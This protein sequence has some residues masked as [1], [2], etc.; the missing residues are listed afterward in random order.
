MPTV[1]LTFASKADLVKRLREEGDHLREAFSKTEPNLVWLVRDSVAPNTFR[2]LRRGKRG[3]AEVFREWAYG[4]LGNRKAV[5]ELTK[6][7]CQ[8]D[9]DKWLGRLAT[10]LS[11][12]WKKQVGLTMPFGPSRKLPNLLLNELAKWSGFSDEERGRLIS[13]LHVPLDSYTLIAIRNCL[14]ETEAS[15]VMIPSSPT[16]RSVEHNETY[17]A[18]QAAVR[19]IAYEAGTQPICIDVLA[20]NLTH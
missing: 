9:Y 20:W 10:D 15:W 4:W 2:G 6:L 16:M 7:S 1:A 12:Q 5:R 13:F 19:Q 8:E 17:V 14:S 3:P 18:L 11:R